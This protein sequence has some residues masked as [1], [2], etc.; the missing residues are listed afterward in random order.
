MKIFI[1]VYTGIPGNVS[2]LK[3]MR[4]SSTPTNLTTRW[5][6]V[7]SLDLNDT[8]P[9]IVYEFE[10][11]DITCGRHDLIHNDTVMVNSTSNSIDPA[12]LY[13]VVVA[14]RNN[15]ANAVNG[16]GADASGTWL[17]LSV[18]MSALLFM[19]IIIIPEEFLTLDA[20]MLFELYTK[21]LTNVAVTQVI[22]FV[23]GIPVYPHYE[24]F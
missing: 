23:G 5:D 8:E 15:V 4:P 18:D 14:A 21:K 9:D 20:T 13:K 10:V 11:Y 1:H 17:F 24:Q 7:F 2:N 19:F 6:S 3:C 22:Y 16:T 12:Q